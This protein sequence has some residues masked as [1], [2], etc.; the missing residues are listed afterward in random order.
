MVVAGHY[1]GGWL[2]MPTQAALFVFAFSS[3]YFSACKHGEKISYADFWKSKM[4]RLLVPLLVFQVFVFLICIA[5]RS[6]GLLSPDTILAFL[7]LTGILRWFDIPRA[8]P[9]GN[10]LWFLTLLWLYYLLFPMLTRMLSRRPLGA[11]LVALLFV[12]AAML[13]HFA[14]QGVF[15]YSTAWFFIL[16]TYIGIHGPGLPLRWSVGAVA[17]IIGI[18]AIARIL[19]IS[20]IPGIAFVMLASM[21]M[22]HGLLVA[23]LPFASNFAVRIFSAWML[24]IYVIHGYLFVRSDSL[25][26]LGGF[27]VSLF[28]IVGMGALLTVISSRIGNRLA[29]HRSSKPQTLS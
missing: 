7:G 6:S 8:S 3:G 2:W 9:M 24:A 29:A 13:E 1:F 5:K 17:A 14:F 25:G 28:I 27:A 23:P 20:E 16:G 4:M 22:M 19:D 12:A 21:P 15:F 10:G 11:V 18:L 26:Q